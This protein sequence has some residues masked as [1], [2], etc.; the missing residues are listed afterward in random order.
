[1]QTYSNN[2]PINMATPSPLPPLPHYLPWGHDFRA[3]KPSNTTRLYYK[4]TNSIGT[5]SFTNGL[6]TLYQ[7]HKGLATNIAM[8]TETNT[9]WQQPTTKSLNE[10]HC[11]N[12]YH[13]TIFAYSTRNTPDKQW[14]QPGG[15]MIAST[16]TIAARHLETGSDT[17]GMGRYCYQKIT[18]TNGRKKI[19]M[20]AYTVCKDSITTAGE[21]T[22]FFHQWHELTKS[23]HKHPNPRRQI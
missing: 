21:S 18:G 11:R 19:F 1:M 10:S 16:G 22:S 14:Y 6:T 9:N 8:Y 12:L 5:R 17:T 23:G 3:P 4:S 20:A 13:N 7:H 15:T 2:P